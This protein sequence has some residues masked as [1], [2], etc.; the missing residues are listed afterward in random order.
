MPAVCICDHTSF[1]VSTHG[2]Y[3]RKTQALV[4]D[5]K[6]IKYSNVNQHD[7]SV[8][9]NNKSVFTAGPHN[10]NFKYK[11]P[12]QNN[13]CLLNHHKLSQQNES[14]R[15]FVIDMQFSSRQIDSI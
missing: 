3:R 14:K 6:T 4:Y 7:I 2:E 15:D 1:F 10:L 13:S 5:R 9:L 8:Y 12:V 11:S